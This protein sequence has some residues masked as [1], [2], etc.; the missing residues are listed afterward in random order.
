MQTC[1]SYGIELALLVKCKHGYCKNAIQHH[2][3]QWKIKAYQI[4]CFANHSLK[5]PR[6]DQVSLALI[7]LL[8][9]LGPKFWLRKVILQPE[10]QLSLLWFKVQSFRC[11][12]LSSIL[13]YFFRQIVKQRFSQKG[14]NSMV[15][16]FSCACFNCLRADLVGR[17]MF[18]LTPL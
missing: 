4:C 3:A 7:Y 1:L 5:I 11:Q 14:C 9:M 13:P 18:I 12:R 17:N 16:C 15:F 2:P 10:G 6:D 8:F